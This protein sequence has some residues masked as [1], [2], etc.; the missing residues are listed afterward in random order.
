MKTKNDFFSI[1]QRKDIVFNFL[2]LEIE[3]NRKLK[4]G[5]ISKKQEKEIRL[6]V[7]PLRY[8]LYLDS[9]E[10]QN[11]EKLRKEAKLLCMNDFL[12]VNGFSKIIRYINC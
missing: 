6:M 3:L 5:K 12:R 2:R 7:K 8:T 10:F 11:N 9:P 1:H 4:E